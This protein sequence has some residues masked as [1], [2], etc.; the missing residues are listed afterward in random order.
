M[1]NN[2]IFM[3]QNQE[4]VGL[5]HCAALLGFFLYVCLSL[6][7]YNLEIIQKII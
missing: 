2:F 4:I 1:L 7:S 6:T 5:V 3:M